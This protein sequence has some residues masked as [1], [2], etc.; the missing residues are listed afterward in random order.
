MSHYNLLVIGDNPEDQLDNF[1]DKWDWYKIGGRWSGSL[2]LKPEYAHLGKARKESWN[3]PEVPAGW[4]DQAIKYQVDFDSMTPQ[5]TESAS[6]EFERIKKGITGCDMPL[7]ID[8]LSAKYISLSSDEVVSMFW[9]Q[10][11]CQAIRKLYPETIYLNP[12]EFVDIEKDRFVKTSV[13]QSQYPFFAVLND[14]EWFEKDSMGWCF[15][16]GTQFTEHEWH[17]L[18]QKLVQEADEDSLLTAID[19]HW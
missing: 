5:L 18:V 14:R 12:M 1:G 3:S 17:D 6:Q 2:K 7:G 8:A 10:P 4:C 11:F 13:L 19:C 9:K 16:P 15:L